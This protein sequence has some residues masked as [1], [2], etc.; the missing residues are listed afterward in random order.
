MPL[1]AEPPQEFPPNKQPRSCKE[2]AEFAGSALRVLDASV[3]IQT[4]S[5]A[6]FPI[7]CDQ[8]FDTLLFDLQK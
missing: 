8:L 3:C 5:V 7:G 2:A 1:R 6:Q 4:H